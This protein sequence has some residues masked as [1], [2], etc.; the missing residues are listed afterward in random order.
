MKRLRTKLASKVRHQH[1]HSLEAQQ[2]QN[3]NELEQTRMNDD[4]KSSEPESAEET[5]N[6]DQGYAA[7]SIGNP[8]NA[9]Q[10]LGIVEDCLHCA[11][12]KEGIEMASRNHPQHIKPTQDR[13]D[14]FFHKPCEECDRCRDEPDEFLCDFCHHARLRHL[15]FC[16][17]APRDKEGM[18]APIQV[19]WPKNHVWQQACKMCYFIAYVCKTQVS[20]MGA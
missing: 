8:R 17:P 13:A 10:Y 2:T 15:S 7:L 12:F 20:E 5:Q 18:H 6:L 9:E 16:L 19:A 14:E 11:T 1:R 3:S 4:A